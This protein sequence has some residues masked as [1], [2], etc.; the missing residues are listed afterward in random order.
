MNILAPLNELFQ[1]VL[2]TLECPKNGKKQG[3]DGPGNLFS[4]EAKAARFNFRTNPVYTVAHTIL[5]MIAAVVLVFV[6]QIC[7]VCLWRCS[8]L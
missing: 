4:E 5:T 3:W 1:K 6:I 2:V 8:S 7:V